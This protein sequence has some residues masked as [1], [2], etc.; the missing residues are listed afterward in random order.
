MT[1]FRL[2]ENILCSRR[3]F[4]WQQG[5][6]NGGMASSMIAAWILCDEICGKSNPY[7]ALFRPQRMNVR[8]GV[9]ESMCGYRKKCSGAFQGDFWQ[10]RRQMSAHGLQTYV[11]SRRKELGLS[12]PWFQV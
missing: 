5:F 7:A 6:K 4:M 10:K 12:M 11:E 1:E 3:I 8:A 2:S 9:A